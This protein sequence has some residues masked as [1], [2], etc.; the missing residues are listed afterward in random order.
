[1]KH[2]YVNIEIHIYFYLDLDYKELLS[3]KTD[4]LDVIR[5]VL[6]KNNVHALAKLASKIP[7]LVSKIA[8]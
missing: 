8:S 6:N 5:P 7:S 1:M 3:E 2:I 4:P